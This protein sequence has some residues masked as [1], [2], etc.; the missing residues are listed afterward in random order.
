M[1]Q[2]SF[3]IV[4][5]NTIK[6]TLQ[7]I[8]SI[9]ELVRGVSYEIIVIDNASHDGSLQ[10]LQSVSSVRVHANETNE[11]FG[12]ANNKGASLAVG[13]YLFFINSDVFLLND[14][15]TILYNYMKYAENECI[16]VC[17]GDLFDANGGKQ[18]SYGNL[19][20]LLQVIGDIGFRRL[21][22][23]YY[24]EKLRLAKTNHGEGYRNV[25]Y[26]SGADW[27]MSKQVFQSAGGFDPD[28]FLYFEETEF[29]HRLRRRG[30]RSMLIPQAKLVHLEGQST[31]EQST[32][33]AARYRLFESSRQLYFRKCF[34]R[35][36]AFIVKV[37]L[38]SQSVGFAI[39]KRDKDFLR[40]GKI[41]W[42]I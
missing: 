19:P 39:V 26:L 27:F 36:Q 22:R 11:G 5:Y 17:G 31:T 32:F 10:A 23:R 3:I 7:C 4:N 38:I 12:R 9:Q 42:K 37:L 34:G 30:Y 16:G 20:S 28:F 8:Q 29:A 33:N 18:V 14:A 13:E 24:E 1:T 40:K 2:V 25:G 21:F 15:A 41:L 6:L 35:V